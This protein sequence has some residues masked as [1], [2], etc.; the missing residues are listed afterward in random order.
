MSSLLYTTQNLVDEV[1]SLLD[2]ENSDSVN[3]ER[4]ILPAL[5][6]AQDFAFDIYS[7]K[8]PEPIL[9][10]EPLALVGNQAEY[11]IPENVFED[12]ILKIES[13][14]SSGAGG[15]TYRD[16]QRIS[17][18]DLSNYESSS[19]T[20]VPYYYCIIGRKI[21]VIPTPTGTYPARV[22]SLRNPEKLVLPQGRI[23]MMNTAG[24]Y[25]I[26][27]STGDNLT[28]ESDQLGSYV[29]WVDGQTGVIKGTL[30]IQSLNEN[31]ITFRTVATRPTVLNRTIAGSLPSDGVQDDYLCA[32]D[33]ICVP[34][35]GRPTGNFMIQF[36]VV[37][38]TGK[39][40]GEVTTVDA[41][42]EMFEKQVER[43]WVGREK[44]MRI[45]KRSHAWGVPT[46][47]WYYE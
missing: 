15:S 1:R 23:T 4:D 37:Q 31:K 35:Y 13:R 40:G 25:V 39:L 33:G 24:N 45:Q 46:R 44:Q 10:A 16:W 3:T 5:N 36:A 9:Q 43:T 8:Y 47:R 41:V 18:R 32:V 38:L 34:Y 42:R 27:D 28:T 7:R 17:Y 14:I 20:N 30:Q 22:W 6:R 26:V 21:R 12:R 2:E 29:N 11:D 19:T